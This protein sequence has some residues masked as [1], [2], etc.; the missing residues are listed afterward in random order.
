MKLHRDDDG[1]LPAY[2]WPGGYQIYYVCADGGVLCPHCAN[3][4]NGS[5]ASEQNEAKDW[6]LVD[7]DVHWE[8]QPLVCDHC[9]T[10]I[11][12]AYGDPSIES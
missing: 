8:G 7:S 2:A 4:K 3:G 11:E 12:S 9:G 5:K 1:K 10:F 6:R